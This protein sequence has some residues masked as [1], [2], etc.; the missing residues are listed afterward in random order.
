[1]AFTIN[2]T[3]VKKLFGEIDAERDVIVGRVFFYGNK[4]RK[5]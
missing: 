2:E 3:R 5:T 1:M 4:D